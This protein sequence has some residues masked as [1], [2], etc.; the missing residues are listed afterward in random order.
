MVKYKGLTTLEVLEDA[1]NYNKWI[2]DQFLPHLKS[3]LLEIGSGTGNISRFFVSRQHVYLSDIDTGLINHLQETFPTKE[4]HIIHLDIE[5]ESPKKFHNYFKT[6]IGINVLE[7]IKNDEQALR[8][9]YQLLKPQGNLLL[10]VPSKRFAYTKLDK[11]LGHYRRYEKDELKE[12][13]VK[14]GFVI[15]GLY[16]FNFVGLISWTIRNRIEQGNHLSKYQIVV[17][18]KIVPLLRAIESV[19]KPFMGVSLIAKARKDSH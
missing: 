16:S 6:I 13:L 14:A 11:R 5:K 8:H 2:I 15:E 12:K 19:I 7:H 18:D 4:K 9:I 17:F 1:Q 10:L 3:P